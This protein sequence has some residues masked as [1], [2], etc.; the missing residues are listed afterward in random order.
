VDANH[1]ITVG[2]S[3]IVLA[4]LAA[5]RILD[6]QSI[7]RFVP[8]GRDNF[9]RSISVME[10]LRASFPGQPFLLEEFGYSNE[11]D[12]RPGVSPI[13]QQATANLEVGMWLYL[14]S[15]GYAGGMKWMLNN[16]PAGQ[17][18]AQNSY[19]IYDDANQP[20]VIAHALGAL[21]PIMASEP[22]PGTWSGP[23]PDQGG[24]IS[25]LYGGANMRFAGGTTTGADATLQ[26]TAEG[27]ATVFATWRTAVDGQIDVW[28]SAPANVGL[29][30]AGTLGPSAL[31]GAL[32][33]RAQGAGG[34]WTPLPVTRDGDWARFNAPAMGLYRL[35]APPPAMQRAAALPG[36][37]YFPET[38]HN[39]RGRFLDYWRRNGGLPIYGYP[40]SEEFQEGG[41]KVQYY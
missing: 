28:V 37:V 19:G 21:L 16:F 36:A 12:I 8:T 31:G 11:A 27:P 29:N 40:L 22:A 9:Q 26:Y 24:A 3:N 13:S 18:A 1:L 35:T 4:K 15:Q 14:Y 2:Y 41:Y 5:N 30:V 20:K 38:G 6:F 33:L 7:H 34:R 23:A 25:F 17:N 10:N 39:L 32:I